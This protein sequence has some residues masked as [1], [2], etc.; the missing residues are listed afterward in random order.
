MNCEGSR[1]V[2]LDDCEM[3]ETYG[4]HETIASHIEPHH[5]LLYGNLNS[6]API[7]QQQ[8]QQWPQ[9]KWPTINDDIQAN[10]GAEKWLDEIFADNGTMNDVLIVPPPKPDIDHNNNKWSWQQ[11]GFF[12]SSN[13]EKNS[14]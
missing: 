11:I 12:N 6:F 2:S 14:R 9:P 7:Q 8:Q 3:K 5:Q 13:G 10:N 1:V 4:R